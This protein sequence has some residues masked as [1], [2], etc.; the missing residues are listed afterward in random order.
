MKSHNQHVFIIAEAGVNHNGDLSLAQQLVEKAKEAG[1]DAVKFQT[2]SAERLAHHELAKADYQQSNDGASETQFSM[3][4]RLELSLEN[5]HIL[6]EYCRI[7]GIQFMS[8]AFDPESTNFLVH[9]LGCDVIKA[10][11]GELTNAPLLLHLARKK[12]KVI[13]STGMSNLSEIEQAL[14]VLA[15]GYLEADAQPSLVEFQKAYNSQKGFEFLQE[16]VTLLHCTSE[17]P[18]SPETINLRTM[19][20]LHQ[21]FK[22]AVGFSDHSL[23]IHIPIAA[24]AMGAQIIEKHVTLDKTLPGPDHKASLDF[25]EFGQM[26]TQIRDIERALGHGRKIPVD[27]EL[28]T[29]QVVRKFL[30]ATQDIHQGDLFTEHNLGSLRVQGNGCSPVLLWSFLGKKSN[31]TLKTG[32]VMSLHHIREF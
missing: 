8:S 9:G 26:V 29:A 1:A 15:F 4:K 17:Y 31:T 11:S 19:K 13:L 24:A 18:A 14:G 30:V 20:T 12:V 5:H 10:G 16:K 6:K 22:L 7:C 28:K 32:D 3:L 23:G 2:F 27:V 25:K 21:A